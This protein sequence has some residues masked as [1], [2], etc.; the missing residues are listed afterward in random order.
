[1]FKSKFATTTLIL[2][3]GGFIT[4]ILGMIIKIVMT[5]IIGTSGIGL[6]M[7]ILPTFNLFIT[8]CQF[9]FP[10]AISKLVAEDKNNNKQIVFSSTWFSIMFNTIIIVLIIA[11]APFISNNLLH[12]ID[13]K[14]PIIAISL[15]LPFISISSIL[16]GYF[17]GKQKMF[18]HILSNCFEQIIRLIII[19]IFIPKFS[20]Y[21]IS[22]IVALIILTNI[23]SELSSILILFLFIPKN[24]KIT[25]KDL[26]YNKSN[27][28]NVFNISIPT[29]SSRIIGSI[30]YFFEPIILTNT[31]LMCGY[32]NTFIVNEY[33]IVN[34]Y[35]LQLV[36]LPSFF[37]LAISQALLPVVSKSYSSGNKKYT[38]NKIK[39]SIYYSL[40]IGIPA[41]ICFLLFPR[42][43]LH[44]IYN[45][46][47][48]ISYI[49]FLAPI[50]ILHY[51][52]SPLAS[53]L[54]AMGKAKDAFLGTVFGIIIRTSL[55]FL[56][57][58]LKIGMWGLII[59]T[60]INIIF[61]TLFDYTKVKKALN[62]YYF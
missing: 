13:T 25:K 42:Q 36:L 46:N 31:L 7:L 17:F 5:R 62:K 14:L 39:Q 50:C 15:T 59:S 48:G 49:R 27:M 32:N 9:G 54:Q 30:G 22:I 16:R 10:I 18:P 2:L 12:N 61:V 57:S 4:K 47:D 38:S 58:L 3:I 33:G 1:M 23:V 60:S 26:K 24:F 51:I 21:S 19:A 6:Y 52:Q 45:T 55:L 28:K 37:T 40:L 41:T 29:T 11:F 35:A 44:L 8:I 53:A 43:L 20:N 56:L 34:G